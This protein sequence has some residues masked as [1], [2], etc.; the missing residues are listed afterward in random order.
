M[1]IDR[2]AILIGDEHL[3]DLP[4]L[5][6]LVCELLGA[7]SI[8]E[9]TRVA[10]AIELQM[11]RLALQ[12]IRDTL[13]GGVQDAIAAQ[14]QRIVVDGAD[15]SELMNLLSQQP[16]VWRYVRDHWAQV[17]QTTIANVEQM[18]ATALFT[19]VTLRF[20]DRTAV[21]NLV[22]SLELDD[23]LPQAF[24]SHM[25]ARIEQAP[26]VTHTSTLEAFERQ[27]LI[28]RERWTESGKIE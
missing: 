18:T 10:N 14:V 23:L 3:F 5:L 2:N 9:R 25:D 19:G 11:T 13:I 12:T 17:R 8:R 26:A 28:A 1:T 4:E 21:A 22:A 16:F 20:A 24:L 27:L 6:T 15:A 7:G